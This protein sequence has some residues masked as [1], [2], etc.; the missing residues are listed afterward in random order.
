MKRIAIIG[1]NSF[2][3]SHLI[4]RLA[5]RDELYLYGRNYKSA[6]INKDNITYIEF[7]HPEISLDFD[8]LLNYDIIIYTAAAGVQSHLHES[9]LLIYDLNFYLPLKIVCFLNDKRYQGKL[10]TFGTYFEIGRND[11]IKAFDE[12]EIVLAKG[13]I[14]NSYCDS[15]RLL[16]RLYN[17]KQFDFNWIHLIIPSLYGPGENEHRLIPYVINS[18]RLKNNLKLSSGEQVRQY[19]FVTDLVDFISLII[20]SAIPPDLYNIAG[21]DEPVKIKDLVTRIHQ[22][23][24]IELTRYDQVDTRDQ[25]MAYLAINTGKVKKDIYNWSPEINLDNGLKICLSNG[26][27][28]KIKLIERSK[29]QD[30]RGWFLKV[31]NGFEDHLPDYTGEMYLTN[32][33]AG[34]TKGG[35]YH[36]KAN[37]W[38]TLIGGECELRLV[39]IATGEKLFFELSFARPITIYVPNHIA[40]IFI[41]RGADQFTLL[42]YSDQL[43]VPEDTILFDDF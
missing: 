7:N 14:P 36:K 26:L 20:D 19:L 29:I 39:D 3:A 11:A 2:L 35:H 37:E 21:P 23:M 34:E 9:G 40:H 8:L 25:N 27:K 13:D 31:M 28:D 15:K 10:I 24:G 43:Y 6:N 41:N 32:A 12:N 38:F 33:L 16:S 1:C 5:K 4:S 17:N 30:H 18:L 42:A 22:L